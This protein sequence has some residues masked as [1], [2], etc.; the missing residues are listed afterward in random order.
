M[1]EENTYVDRTFSKQRITELTNL[2]G[3]SL[4][5]FMDDYR[6]TISQAKKMTDYDMVIYIKKSYADFINNY[7]HEKQSPFSNWT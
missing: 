7:K 3:D 6:P 2:K 4:L 1:D 5:N